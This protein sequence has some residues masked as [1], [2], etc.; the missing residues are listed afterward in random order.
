MRIAAV[1]ELDQFE[2]LDGILEDEFGFLAVPWRGVAV[3][4]HDGELQ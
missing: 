4:A 2:H 1:G 3:G